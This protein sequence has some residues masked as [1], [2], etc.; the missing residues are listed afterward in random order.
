[1]DCRPPG[2]HTGLKPE[3]QRDRPS[4]TLGR[5]E[6]ATVGG[7]GGLQGEGLEGKQL[8]QRQ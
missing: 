1:M 5:A 4:Q 6:E 7:A 2:V 8:R 3:A